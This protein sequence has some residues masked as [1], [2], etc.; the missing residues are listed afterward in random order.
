MSKLLL[1]DK[2]GTIVRPKSGAKFV[3]H[4]EDQELIPGA[5]EAID[6]Y[7]FDDWQIEIVSNQGGVKAGFKTMEQANLEMEFCLKLISPDALPYP[8]SGSIRIGAAYFCPDDGKTCHIVS[9]GYY[10]GISRWH[11]GRESS[12]SGNY[13]K[14]APG[15][16]LKALGR[17]RV[18]N[19]PVTHILMVGDRPE[20][21]EA[22]LAAAVPFQWAED[23]RNSGP[24]DGS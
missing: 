2:D 17:C 14:P 9:V 13:R 23:W 7:F 11:W 20:D 22:A 8:Q 18:N 1:L 15:M 10:R 5:M 6:R 12:Y 3:Q 4:P 21:E 19:P 16:L 24:R